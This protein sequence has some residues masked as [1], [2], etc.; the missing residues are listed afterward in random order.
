[1]WDKKIIRKYI[2]GKRK[3]FVKKNSNPKLWVQAKDFTFDSQQWL[4]QIFMDSIFT[5]VSSWEVKFN[6]Y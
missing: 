3:N 6:I 5:P 1:M 2:R 4:R